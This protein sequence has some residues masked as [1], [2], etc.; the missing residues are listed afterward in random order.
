M[1]EKKTN[2]EKSREFDAANLHAA[3]EYLKPENIAKYGEESLMVR[4]ARAT[5]KRLRPDDSRGREL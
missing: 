1:S 3:Y 2:L 5:I 4:V